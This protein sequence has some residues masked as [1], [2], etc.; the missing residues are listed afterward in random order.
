MFLGNVYPEEDWFPLSAINRFVYC[1]RRFALVHIEGL[2][3]ENTHTVAGDF[4]HERVHDPDFAE[5]RG[6]IVQVRAVR[7][8]SETLGV[9]GECDMLELRR[10]PDGVK[11]HGYDGTW[12]IYPVEYKKGKQVREGDKL[13]LCCQAM[14]LE[15]MLCCDIP[16]GAVY[17][18][19]IRRRESV[20]LDNELRSGVREYF[21]EMHE[22]RKR[23]YTPKAKYRRACRECSLYDLCLPEL[24][25]SGTVADYLS[26]NIGGIEIV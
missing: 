3:A 12:R 16:E 26:E 1:R 10:D 19:A 6:D 22:L 13:Q 11:I 8:F 2:W 18:G 24:F 7:V 9:S 21:F 15:E 25:R 14:C 23:G 20:V 17:L 4:L 5:S